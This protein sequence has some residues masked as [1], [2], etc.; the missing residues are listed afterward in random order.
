[1]KKS[2]LSLLLVLMTTVLY[3]GKEELYVL[4]EGFEN[5]IPATWSQINEAGQQQ[6]IIES[7]TDAQYPTGVVEGEYRAALR[8]TTTQT[9]HFVT[10]LVTP[11]FDIS[12]TV[13]PILVFACASS[14]HGR[15]GSTEGLLPSVRY[16]P[17]D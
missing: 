3:A 9:Q 1:M 6:W 8:N 16:R 5:G 14:A 7:A 4:Y 12:K 15:C 13:H 10:K 11:V 17:L 2:F